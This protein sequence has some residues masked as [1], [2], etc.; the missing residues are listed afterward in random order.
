MAAP[1]STTRL[2]TAQ[3]DDFIRSYWRCATVI[4]I[5]RRLGRSDR[6]VAA[7]A[8][9]LGLAAWADRVDSHHAS[10]IA[11]TS[12]FEQRLAAVHAR[13]GAPLLLVKRAGAGGPA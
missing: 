9:V 1:I 10:I 4:E 12:R 13:H 11:A 7:R 8:A 3:E 5:A 6:S 2:Y